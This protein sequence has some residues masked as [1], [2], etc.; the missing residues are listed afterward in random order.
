MKVKV[1]RS[2]SAFVGDSMVCGTEG[3]VLD[4][5]GGADW[6]RAGLAVALEPETPAGARKRAPETAV[7]APADNA[8]LPA[9][10]KRKG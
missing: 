10:K 7:V 9:G 3:Q 6:I 2:F 4:L 1:V 5:P 8:V